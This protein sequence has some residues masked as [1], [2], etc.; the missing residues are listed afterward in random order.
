MEPLEDRLLPNGVT[1]ITHGFGNNNWGW[2]TSMANEVVYEIS[3]RFRCDVMDV[4]GI[5]LTVNSDLTVT[6][7]WLNQTDLST[8]KCSET[9]VLLDWSAVAGLPFSSTVDVATAVA[10]CLYERLSDFGLTGMTTPLADGPIQLIGHSRGGSLVGELAKDLGQKGIWV[11][12]VTTLDPHPWSPLASD[13]PMT[14]WNNVVFW[15]NYWEDTFPYPHGESIS[16]TYNNYLNFPSGGSVGYPDGFD[17]GE[18]S[19]VHLWYQGTL[20]TEVIAAM[21]GMVSDGS[22]V[23]NAQTDG[24]YGG[25]NPSETTSG[26]YFSRI[27]G[28]D[29]SSSAASDGLLWSDLGSRS[30]VSLTVPDASAWDNVEIT[31]LLQGISLNQG[32]PVPLDLKYEAFGDTQITVGFDTD[33][34]PYNNGG[35]NLHWSVSAPSSNGN[36]FS[37]T[38]TSLSTTGLT[39]GDSYYVYAQIT[40][41]GH[42]RYYYAPG[43]VHVNPP[44]NQPPSIGSLSASP[45]PVVLGNNLTLTAN[46][47]TDSDGRVLSVGFYRD[48]NGNGSID[49]DTDELLG[50]ATNSDATWSWTGSTSGFPTGTNTY[51]ASAEDNDYAF[52]NTVTTT[53]TVSLVLDYSYTTSNGKITITGYTGP[54]GAVTIP[55]TINGLPVTSIGECAFYSCTSLTGVYFEGNAP[56]LDPDVFFGNTTAT[57]Y[58]MPETTG[59]TNPWGGRPTALWLFPDFS[60][61]TT[62]NGTITITGYTGAGGA[63]TIPSTIN[64]LPVTSIG[65]EAF[66]ECTNLT[67]V[68]ISNGVTTIER[69]AF[70]DCYNLTNVTIGNSVTS[71][72]MDVFFH[73]PMTSLVIPSSLTSIGDDAFGYCASPELRGLRRGRQ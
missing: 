56:S 32:S 10:P 36:I 62:T 46:N 69:W 63:V 38:N 27:G 35:S 54:G 14:A 66:F 72:G 13:A 64:G 65:C 34:N 60:Y 28:G 9:V 5:K 11:D 50:I 15:D 49:I 61:Y 17:G 40:H 1:L 59:W 18:H 12:Q 44:A 55:S 33:A 21:G 45:N 57:V 19:D 3:S 43:A 20:N 52:S 24:W 22:Y 25:S 4:A 30:T 73:C 37:S 71:I 23:F 68:T 7:T 26:Y 48:V 58:Y 42:T 16:G 70:P 29:R 6:P 53:G 2:V 47:V 51:M 39:P 31:S 41:A 67:S 8:S